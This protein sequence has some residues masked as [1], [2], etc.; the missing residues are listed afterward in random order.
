MHNTQN[1]LHRHSHWVQAYSIT[2]T[3]QECDKC[4][5]GFLAHVLNVTSKVQYFRSYSIP[6]HSIIFS[7]IF[8]LQYSERKHE[9]V[10]WCEREPAEATNELSSQPSSQQQSTCMFPIVF[11]VAI[12][13]NKN[14]INVDVQ[15]EEHHKSKA[16]DWYGCSEELYRVSSDRLFCNRNERNIIHSFIEHRSTDSTLASQSKCMAY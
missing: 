3:K 5:V 4:C 6:F 10:Y 7:S 14:R 15:M 13:V 1:T 12:K 11:A 16:M 2:H 8:L 9:S